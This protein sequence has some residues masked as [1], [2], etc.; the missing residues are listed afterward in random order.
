M[1]AI[2]VKEQ[3]KFSTEKTD[4]ATAKLHATVI[5]MA[6]IAA[7]HRAKKPNSIS[8]GQFYIELIQGIVKPNIQ[9]GIDVTRKELL[10]AAEALNTREVIAN[11]EKKIEQNNT[12]IGHKRSKIVELLQGDP[13]PVYRKT[14]RKNIGRNLTELF[15]YVI[16]GADALFSF[17]NYR[18][19]GFSTGISFAMASFVFSGI[20]LSKILFIPWIQKTT[21][22]KQGLLRRISALSVMAV[23]F[24][25][26]SY[27]RAHGN[28]SVSLDP[29][30]S[31][32]TSSTTSVWPQFIITYIL[33]LL[34]FFFQLRNWKSASQDKAVAKEIETQDLIA[35]LTEEI[36]K[37]TQENFDGEA[38]IREKKA[39]IRQL[40]DYYHKQIRILEHIGE[41]AVAKYK[42]IYSSYVQTIPGFFMTEQKISYDTE[43]TF[44]SP[45]K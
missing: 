1:R 34:I 13:M 39:D 7:E 14:K 27:Y 35:V 29:G 11:T 26:I 37:L 42:K 9:E 19:A 25:F 45:E 8:E 41:T 32:I 4:A 5:P 36:E 44:I 43:L 40:S 6:E 12:D 3:Y 31:Q 33:F 16:A 30:V 2:K 10:V 28:V 23:F 18:T 15:C 22:N 24:Y 17:G 20:I 21:S 38:M